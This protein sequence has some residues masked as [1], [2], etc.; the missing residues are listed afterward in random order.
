MTGGRPT[1]AGRL[2]H[3]MRRRGEPVELRVVYDDRDQPPWTAELVERGRPPMLRSGATVEAAIMAVAL[4]AK[5]RR[6][7]VSASLSRR[8]G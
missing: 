1:I 5:D 8:A 3:L 7:T 4:A 2:N 6:S